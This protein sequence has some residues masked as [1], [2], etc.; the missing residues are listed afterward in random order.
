VYGEQQIHSDVE[1]AGALSRL[2][3]DASKARFM[4]LGCP[5]PGSIFWGAS[6]WESFKEDK[7]QPSF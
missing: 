5:E 3:A 6:S 2:L 1:Q 7:N 4:E